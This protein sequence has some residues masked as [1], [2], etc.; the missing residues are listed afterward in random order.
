MA[1]KEIQVGAALWPSIVSAKRNAD[2]EHQRFQYFAIAQRRV[3]EVLL[4]DLAVL[5]DHG[6]QLSD[7]CLLGQA[8]RRRF[9]DQPGI[10]QRVI[11]SRHVGQGANRIAVV[12]A[13]IH[14][15][16]FGHTKAQTEDQRLPFIN[17]ALGNLDVEEQQIFI[18]VVEQS[19]LF[20]RTCL[21]QVNAVAG[22]VER[23]F[24]LGTTTD[25]ANSVMERR[26]EALFLAG[27]ADFA[28]HIFIITSRKAAAIRL[29]TLHTPSAHT[30]VIFLN[31]LPCAMLMLDPEAK[32]KVYRVA[33]W[34]VLAALIIAIILALKRP[35]QV[36]EAP[37]PQQ[38]WKQQAASFQAKLTQ[39]EQSNAEGKQVQI[40]AD[41]VNAAL[42][43]S[44]QTGKDLGQVPIEGAPQVS[45]E[46]NQVRG[47]FP[48][49][50]YGRD[51]YVTVS[52]RLGSQN[53]YATFDPTEF[54]VGDLT[55]P[56]S[57]VNNALQKKLADPENHK[58]LKLPEFVGDVR[59]VDG[60]LVITQ[61]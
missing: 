56:V 10:D 53:G 30:T 37:V 9:V 15:C 20:I 58:K 21:L 57:L 23:D 8:R 39:L 29:P 24:A 60:Q 59:V 41:E 31:L 18:D 14:A 36:A 16:R 34:F 61:K 25:R 45:F 50:M 55:V 44:M 3:P 26:A 32:L 33:R 35:A 42:R 28:G 47:V 12:D 5:L 22:A 6:P 48:T 51:V 1:E 19:R 7:D 52:G 43:E 4:F 40:S 13:A 38:A 27:M 2:H 46:N 54:K 49:K 11:A 17:E